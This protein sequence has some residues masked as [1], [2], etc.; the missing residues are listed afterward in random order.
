LIFA[1][2]VLLV[3]IIT[4]INITGGTMNFK[5][6]L[7]PADGLALAVAM[8]AVLPL[9]NA[10]SP[11][12]SRSMVGEVACPVGDRFFIENTVRSGEES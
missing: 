4:C 1:I 3:T 7:I 10:F 2:F 8:Q 9:V 6:L 5:E 11:V 12:R